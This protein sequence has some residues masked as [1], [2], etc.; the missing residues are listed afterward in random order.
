MRQILPPREN[1]PKLF[2]LLLRHP[3]HLSTS[4]LAAYLLARTE[5]TIREIITL[6]IRAVIWAV[7]MSQES[8]DRALLDAIEYHPPS[9][10]RWLFEGLLV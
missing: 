6:L 10:R 9:A 2:V 7:E 4:A 1:R 8:L 5:G 3:S